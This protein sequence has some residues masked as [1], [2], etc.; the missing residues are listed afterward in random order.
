M[1]LQKISKG[2]SNLPLPH[3]F[4][5]RS[6]FHPYYSSSHFTLR[7]S[8][9]F[10]IFPTLLPSLLTSTAFALLPLSSPTYFTTFHL[11]QAPPSHFPS[12]PLPSFPYFPATH[13]LSFLLVSAPLSSPTLISP[14][15]HPLISHIP[16]L[17]ISPHFPFPL[18][19]SFPLLIHPSFLLTI[20]LSSLLV[21]ST[22]LRNPEKDFVAYLICLIFIFLLHSRQF[23][24]CS[25]L[26]PN[27]HLLVPHPSYST[28][29]YPI[30]S[31]TILSYCPLPS[32]ALH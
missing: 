25:R 9:L 5:L 2:S 11:P 13:F 3:F 17:L 19:S 8:S 29:L 16:P 26:I 15:S 12:T 1:R 30:L 32:L 6:P 28:L 23:S 31:C 4:F 10:Q 22:G 18:F 7:F 24:N 20:P 21:S 27:F 14:T